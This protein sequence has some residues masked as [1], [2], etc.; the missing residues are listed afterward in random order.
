MNDKFE[1]WHNDKY[2]FPSTGCEADAPCRVKFKIEQFDIATQQ[3][4][5]MP[6]SGLSEDAAYLRLLISSNAKIELPQGII[7]HAGAPHFRSAM[8]LALELAKEG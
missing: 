3:T 8:A 4:P 5:S 2:G 6:G 1:Q 7:I